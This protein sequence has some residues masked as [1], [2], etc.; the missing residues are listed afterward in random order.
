MV[1]R[2]RLT[3]AIAVVLFGAAQSAHGAAFNLQEQ[4]ASRLGTAFAGTASAADDTSTIFFNVAG[5]AELDSREFSVVG[6]GIAIKSE[7]E[8]ENSVAAFGQPL[9]DEGG[10]AGGWSFV[11]AAYLA[12]PINDQVAFG[13]GINV[14]FGLS[15]NYGER[16]M[17]RFQ[18]VRSEIET[19][20]VNPA[21]SWKINDRVSVGVGIN[22]QTVEAVLTNAVNYSAVI[23]QGVSQL[24]AGGG[25]SPAAGLG[26][27][28]ATSQLEG[29]TRLEGDDE[30][31][32]YNVG[33]LFRLGESTR[34]GLSYRSAIEYT[35]EGAAR[36]TPPAIANPVGA[37]IVASAS[38]PNGPVGS[39]DAT[40]D[41]ELPDI[42]IASITHEL[43]PSLEVSADVAWTGWSSVQ[44]LRV[45]RPN[46]SVLSVTPEEW[47]DT[48]R[49]SIGAAWRW[50]ED[51]TLRAG[52]MR[53]ESAVPDSTRTPRLPDSDRVLVAIGAQ[54]RPSDAM[55]LDFGYGHLFADDA[56]VDQD[57]ENAA[58]YGWLR[59]EQTT[60]IDL[61]S[62]Q[63][64][65]RF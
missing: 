27:L 65:Y 31:W 45:V 51:I 1:R 46:G 26:V 6:S 55:T 53:D 64:S 3:S 24:V 37:G 7:F 33:V 56:P 11:P 30:A 2:I 25:L 50:R 22:Y 38:G 47:E 36:F 14:P 61:I 49:L 34:V 13:L 62:A 18:A 29:Q 48:V 20:N 23:A 63:L 19:I 21:V 57:A 28:T 59:G 35:V 58:A 8:N 10:D 17:G 43:T 54:W 60:T 5:L 9:G 41:L 44:E 12:W 15:L 52:V 39:T 40:V 32:G 42:A 16:W 4:A